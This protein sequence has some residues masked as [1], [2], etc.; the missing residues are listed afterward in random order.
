[1]PDLDD[2]EAKITPAYKGDRRHQPNN[3]TGAVYPLEVLEGIAEL[4]R[5]HQLVVM[6]DEIYDKI[7]YDEATHTPSVRAAPD[8]FTLTFNGLSRRT[9]WLDSAARG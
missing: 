3:P 8:L 4:A 5:R 6:A 2:L 9:G 7:L 1:M